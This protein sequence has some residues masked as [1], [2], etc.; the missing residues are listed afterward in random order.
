MTTRSEPI[1]LWISLASPAI[2]ALAFIFTIGKEWWRGRRIDIGIIEV[3]HEGNQYIG[4]EDH[5][6]RY[7][8]NITDCVGFVTSRRGNNMFLAATSTGPPSE[9]VASRGVVYEDRE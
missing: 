5:Q 8:A 7:V 3:P 1:A 9:D 2:S 4:R 6:Q